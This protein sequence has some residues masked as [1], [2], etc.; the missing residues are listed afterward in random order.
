MR[1]A[2]LGKETNKEKRSICQNVFCLLFVDIV[3]A[4]AKKFQVINIYFCPFKIYT[5]DL[6]NNNNVLIMACLLR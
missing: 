3:M 5:K 2:C 6:S 1:F 4:S